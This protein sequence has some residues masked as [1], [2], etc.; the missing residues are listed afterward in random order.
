MGLKHGHGRFFDNKDN[1][2]YEGSFANDLFNG[3]GKFTFSDGS[4]FKGV[5]VNGV[6]DYRLE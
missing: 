2:L 3:Q 5:F 1:S 6:L 4:C